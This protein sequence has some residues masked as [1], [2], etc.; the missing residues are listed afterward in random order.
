M[1]TSSR[2][3][4]SIVMTEEWEALAE[5]NNR[6]SI[7]VI[8]RHP[9]AVSLHRPSHACCLCLYVADIFHLINF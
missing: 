3:W 6:N 7:T 9:K 5:L 2:C 8:C 1:E 4:Q